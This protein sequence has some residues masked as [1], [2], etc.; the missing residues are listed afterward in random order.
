MTATDAPAPADD[1]PAYTWWRLPGAA[2]GPLLAFLAFGAFAGCW[3]ALLP[4][5]R[6]DSHASE[7]QLG[8]AMLASAGGAFPAVLISGWLLDRFGGRIVGIALV[9]LACA[10]YGT[11]LANTPLQLVLTLVFVGFAAGATDISMNAAVAHVEATSRPL[12]NFAHALFSIGAAIGGAATG[13]LREASWSAS[14][15]SG[16]L[17]VL[18]VL[19]AI[20]NASSAAVK[21]SDQAAKDGDSSPI[22]TN[23][24]LL[25]IG[26]LVFLSFIVEATAFAWTAIHVED[27]FDASARVGGFAVA[28]YFSG[29][30]VGRLVAHV[31]G[32]STA[33]RRLI[34]ASGLLIA[35]AG[36]AIAASPTVGPVIIAFLFLGLGTAAVAPTL[37]S[38]AGASEPMRRGAAIA[39]VALIGFLGNVSGAA[40]A[41]FVAEQAS[42]RWSFA[43][44]AGAGVALAIGTILVLH[45][46]AATEP[47]PPDEHVGQVPDSLG[48][49]VD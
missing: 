9:G 45:G 25:A 23:V 39:T 20:G 19:V 49:L 37:Y 11:S 35:V 30:V 46:R 28:A 18:V 14:Q 16:S 1:A 21:P 38:V 2:A 32:N 7:G 17:G 40:L 36:A 22:F 31:R 24:F 44:V 34:F 15:V 27:T 5:L 4:Q 8:L 3:S 10:A 47:V 43:V 33:P 42:L 26:M 41:G 12:M 29:S 13:L 48:G 6:V